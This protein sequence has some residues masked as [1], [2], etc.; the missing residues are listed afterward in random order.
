MTDRAFWDGFK[1]GTP[2]NS[3]ISIMGVPFDGAVSGPRGAAEAPARL[4]ELSKRF[5]P[6]SE[7][8]LDLRSLAVYDRGDVPF[9]RDWE[10]Y[11][12]EVENQ[13]LTLFKNG[14]IPLFL[15]G[16]HSVTIP[17]SRA[18][19]RYYHPDPVGM[20]HL[21]AHTDLMDIYRGQKWS[22]ACPQRRFLEQGNA[23]ARHLFLVGIREFEAEEVTFWKD[24]PDLGLVT[25]RR[26]YRDGHKAVMKE[27]V[28]AME[29]L[30]AV[31]LSIDIDILDPAYAPG[32]GTPQAGGLS[33]REL[34]ELVTDTMAGLP[35]KAVDLVEV[36]PPLDYSD[37]TSRAALKVIYEVF[38]A[39]NSLKK[40]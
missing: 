36:A 27:M 12:Y 13:A 2:E 40:L 25:A 34:I 7:E 28:S 30:E 18:F 24:N 4:R 29:G 17:L 39:I 23:K 15:G 14:G 21:D 38:A 6:F 31:Y 33:T 1:A 8:G 11:Y 19:S 5:S 32:T 22:H 16:D 20:V 9:D 26:Y 37:I 35:V 3:D 10:R